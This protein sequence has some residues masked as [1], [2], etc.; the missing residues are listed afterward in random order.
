MQGEAELDPDHF[1]ISSFEKAAIRNLEVKK[2]CIL[3]FRLAPKALT[4]M[5][6]F[7]ILLELE[8]GER[9]MIHNSPSNIGEKGHEIV[10]REY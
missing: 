6:H 4:F 9:Y 2:A 10:I 5:N 1:E 3:L 7:G 8:N